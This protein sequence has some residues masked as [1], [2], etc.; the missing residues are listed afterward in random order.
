MTHICVA[1]SNSSWLN[2]TY[3]CCTTRALFGSADSLTL[4]LKQKQMRASLCQDPLLA[5]KNEIV[6]QVSGFDT[7]YI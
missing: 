7:I 6:Y 5:L 1:C 3:I 2:V 4:G